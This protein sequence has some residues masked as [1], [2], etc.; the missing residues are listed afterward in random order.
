LNKYILILGV[1][2]LVL[3]VDNVNGEGWTRSAG[4]SLWTLIGSNIYRDS[5]V[6][7]GTG[8][9]P[10]ADLHIQTNDLASTELRLQNTGVGDSELSFYFG[11][12]GL[13]T[14]E[15]SFCVNNDLSDNLLLINLGSDCNSDA[16]IEWGRYGQTMKKGS[17]QFGAYTQITG[18]SFSTRYEN[19]F[20]TANF[21]STTITS[22]QYGQSGQIIYVLGDTGTTIQD[23]SRIHLSGGVDFVMTDDDT[24]TMIYDSVSRDWFELSRSV[25]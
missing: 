23:N 10:N 11:S 24:L 15:W 3:L 4:E 16:L 22:F 12:G 18:S 1:L 13:S 6:G 25:N 21:I 9:D 17:L 7:I 14:R 2:S 20:K 19:F 5:D 8:G